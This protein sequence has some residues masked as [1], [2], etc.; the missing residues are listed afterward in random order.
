MP[1]AAALPE[2]QENLEDLLQ[3]ETWCTRYLF[4]F[5]W[6]GDFICPGCGRNGGQRRPAATVTCRYC[7]KTTSITT[8]TLLHAT[9]KPLSAWLQA[10]WWLSAAPQQLTGKSLQR[11]LTIRS[12]QTA[13]N[14][15]KILREA[16]KRAN[17]QRCSGTIEIDGG[18]IAFSK[19]GST[20]RYVLAAV[21]VEPKNRLAG[22]LH[23]AQHSA[24]ISG[25]VARFIEEHTEPGSTIL[26]P[27]RSP[28]YLPA[29]ANRLYLIETG[30]T[31]QDRAREA[32]EHCCDCFEEQQG[33]KHSPA[34]FQ[35]YL[36]EFC[37][38]T[39]SARLANRRMVF[40]QLIDAVLLPLPGSCRQ[41]GEPCT[42]GGLP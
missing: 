13:W 27:D 39:N 28:F 6:P 34:R 14:W 18:F 40:E 32:V 2:L 22:R 10:L 35:E 24:L 16:M 29:F 1:Q 25:Q 17:R 3:N 26:A 4:L 5:R 20:G 36:D 38:R 15:M 33:P 42:A 37:F 19:D 41:S 11:R 23:L 8:G 12:Y 30:C 21:E 7:G 9:K 31:S